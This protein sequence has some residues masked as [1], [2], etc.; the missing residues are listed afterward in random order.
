MLAIVTALSCI[1]DPLYL[2]DKYIYVK[3]ALVK[4]ILSEKSNLSARYDQDADIQ[5]KS[6]NLH[7]FEIN[8]IWNL[9]C[10]LLML[11]KRLIFNPE[12]SYKKMNS[13]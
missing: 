11:I 10:V 12:V 9:K 6:S 4:I 13:F 2:K 8:E 1:L 7:S 5:R 3:C